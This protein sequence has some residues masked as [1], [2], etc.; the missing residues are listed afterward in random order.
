MTK[1]TSLLLV[2]FVAIWTLSGA[3]HAAQSSPVLV[4]LFNSE[5]CSSCPPADALLEELDRTQEIS[6][7]QLI[8]LSEHVDYWDHIGWRDPYSSHFFTDRQGSYAH[9]F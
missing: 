6:G 5:G 3:A 2:G 1:L 4:E 7:T 8:V 9:H